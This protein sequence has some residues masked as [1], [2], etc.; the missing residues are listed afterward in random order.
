MLNFAWFWPIY[1]DAVIST[2]DWL[3]RIWFKAW[4]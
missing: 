4:I 2:P 1:T 3:D